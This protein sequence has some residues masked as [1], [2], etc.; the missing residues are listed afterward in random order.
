MLASP[1]VYTQSSSSHYPFS[2]WL[3]IEAHSC[4][5]HGRHHHLPTSTPLFCCRQ[6]RDT[7]SSLPV[8]PKSQDRSE[9]QVGE[10]KSCL[11]LNVIT[12]LF[13]WVVEHN[14]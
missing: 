8:K 1:K 9:K 3:C 13:C 2:R 7:A 5:L 10:L 14:I 6:Q 12:G 11:Q 4:K